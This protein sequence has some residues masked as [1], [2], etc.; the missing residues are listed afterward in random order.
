MIELISPQG[1]LQQDL[2]QTQIRHQALNLRVLFLPMPKF[3]DLVRLKTPVR[4]F[5]PVERGL[6]DPKLAHILR[7]RGA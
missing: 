6:G 3:D 7:D 4:L 5:P 1:I 2:L